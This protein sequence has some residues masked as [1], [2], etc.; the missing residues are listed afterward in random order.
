[1]F[2]LFVKIAE[3]HA[4]TWGSL[5]ITLKNNIKEDF[6]ENCTEKIMD[7]RVRQNDVSCKMLKRV[8]TK[9]YG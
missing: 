8:S 4:E 7:D 9:W 2:V 1:M 3:N 5:K 6:T